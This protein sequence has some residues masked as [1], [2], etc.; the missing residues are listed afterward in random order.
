MAHIHVN[1]VDLVDVGRTGIPVTVYPNVVELAEY[2]IDTG[3]IFPREHAKA[4]GLLALLLRRIHYYGRNFRDA[5]QEQ[6]Q[7][8][9]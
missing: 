4:G 2:T 3:K 5:T 7:A 9:G 6:R 8:C 1:L